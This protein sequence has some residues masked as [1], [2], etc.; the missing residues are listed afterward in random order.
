MTALATLDDKPPKRIVAKPKTKR[1]RKTKGK[2]RIGRP[3]YTY[4][5]KTAHTVCDALAAGASLNRLAGK[6]GLPHKTTIYRW[7]AKE[8]EFRAM[9]AFATHCRSEGMAE[10]IV[11]IADESLDPVL[12]IETRK[13]LMAKQLPKRYGLK[14]ED[15]PAPN[16]DDAK[17]VN[18]PQK[19][20]EAD[21]LYPQVL[22]WEQAVEK[23]V[24]L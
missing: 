5:E 8:P 23:V 24:K 2:A 17:T 7:L 20:I 19:M 18:D 21:P 6:A 1:K 10:E 13:W 9:Y 15:V 11:D 4:S 3:P 16:G 22:A 12:R 14:P